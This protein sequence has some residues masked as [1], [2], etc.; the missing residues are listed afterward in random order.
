MTTAQQINSTLRG[1][2]APEMRDLARRAVQDGWDLYTRPGGHVDVVNPANG[3]V[4]RLSSTGYAGPSQLKPKR[5]EFEVAG[6]DLRSKAERR[7]AD[8]LT[9]A[10]A[11]ARRV[12]AAT[13]PPA[14]NVDPGIDGRAIEVPDVT[15]QRLQIE[16]DTHR[17]PP[18]QSGEAHARYRDGSTMFISDEIAMVD[19]VRLRIR[20]QRGGALIGWTPPEASIYDRK[21]WSVGPRPLSKTAPP[22]TLEEQRAEL[23]AKVRDW[24]AAGKPPRKPQPTRPANERSQAVRE[25]AMTKGNGVAPQP[26][27][28]D[29]ATEAALVATG[30]LRPGGVVWTTARVDPAEFPIAS[31]LAELHRAV[32]PA[33]AALEA[34]GRADAA[35]LVR[36]EL[37]N[38]PAEQE[39]LRLWQELTERPRLEHGPAADG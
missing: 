10:R 18:P 11:A 17:P 7:R 13:P 29:L 19:G 35:A 20:Q 21:S 12:L 22:R 27:A 32:G 14:P 31:A 3:A 39:L 15:Q 1:F 4:V 33:I 28:E 6:L 16:A 37:A 25:A 24:I 9:R 26:D 30:H 23:E 36:A 2:R 34:A 38:T 8:R 5:H